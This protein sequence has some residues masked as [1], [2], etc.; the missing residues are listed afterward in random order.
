MELDLA[1]LDP[2]EAAVWMM[3][4]GALPGGTKLRTVVGDARYARVQCRGRAIS[5][6]ARGGLMS[7]RRGWSAWS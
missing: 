6:C 3:E 7:R 5:G 2:L 1:K 4:H